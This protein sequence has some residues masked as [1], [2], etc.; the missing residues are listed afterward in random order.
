[1]VCLLVFGLALTLV[2]CDFSFFDDFFGA[3]EDD[4]SNGGNSSSTTTLSGTYYLQGY[5]EYYITF[6]NNGAVTAV[7]DGESESA[8]Y[9]VSGSTITIRSGAER[10]YL[11]IVDSNTIRDSEGNYWVKGGSNSGGAATTLSGTYYAQGDSGIYVTFYSNGTVI[12]VVD[13][14]FES[15]TY[16]VS[17]ATITITS[18]AETDYWYI[19]DSNTIRDSEGG[20]WIKP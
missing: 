12:G 5:S 15:A 14:E 10:D 11:Y 7:F 2:S 3:E 6:Y 1:M 13:G 9:T 4:N 16:T 19:V 17:G 8:T 18:E 20:Y